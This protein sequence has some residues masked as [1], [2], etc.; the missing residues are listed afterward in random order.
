MKICIDIQTA[1]H[2]PTGIG[3][4][5][6][7]LAKHLAAILE[8]DEL[9]LFYFDFIRKKQT[10]NIENAASK[11]I[12]WLPERIMRRIWRY[13]KLPPFNILAGPA[14]IYHFTNFFFTTTKPW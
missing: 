7:E 3:H 1:L 9:I 14:N 13:L 8:P 12:R 10:I 11:S 6:K 4:Y 2:Q 5:A